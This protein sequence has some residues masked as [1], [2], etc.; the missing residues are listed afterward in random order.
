MRPQNHL[1]TF[2]EL[3][4]EMEQILGKM[5]KKY[6]PSDKY[7]SKST[8]RSLQIDFKPKQKINLLGLHNKFKSFKELSKAIETIAKKA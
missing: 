6:P 7:L 3:N 2:K 1:R 4:E 5:C 8:I